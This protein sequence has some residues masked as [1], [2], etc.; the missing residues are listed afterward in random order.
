MINKMCILSSYYPSD[1]DPYYTFVGS[2]VEQFADMGIECHV[3]TP[4]SQMEKL[5]KG[6][7]RIETTKKGNK[8]YVYCP[9]YIVFPSRVIAGFYSYK[10]TVFSLWSAIRR[11][12]KKKIKTSDVIY[13]HF[14]ES[15]L[16]AAWLK[17]QTGIPAFM[18]VGES[19]VRDKELTYKIFKDVLYSGLDG[20]I[21]VSTY[22]RNELFENNIIDKK[23]RTLVAP[24]G[25]N[26]DI[27]YPR[28]KN[29]CRKKL[30]LGLD[31]FAI[32]FVGGYIKRKGFD[33]LQQA[34][35]NHLEWKCIFIGSGDIPIELEPFQVVFNGRVEHDL[36]PDYLSA[37]DVFVLPTTA[38]G[39]CN[40]IIEAM[41]CGLPIISSNLPFNE[42]IL[43]NKNAILINPDRV[44][45]IENALDNISKNII[46]RNNLSQNALKTVETLYLDKR[47]REI[48]SFMEGLI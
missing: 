6:E 9:R 27:F 41:A 10:L 22:I 45:E 25:I 17:K 23:I 24:N 38:E 4:V 42:D 20:V 1:S 46:L 11:V 5:H 31:D 44:H 34:I 21:C 48:I 26:P 36:I 29:V 18:A 7:T 39:C 33:K 47:A 19:R 2:L 43:S 15:G 37:A 35:K 32:A 16:N 30:G 12:F 13:S 40:A 8:I 28:D 3:I 14:I